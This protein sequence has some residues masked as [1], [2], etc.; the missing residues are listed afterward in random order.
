MRKNKPGGGIKSVT[1][2]DGSARPGQADPAENQH[3]QDSERKSYDWKCDNRYA[4]IRVE[5]V[6]RVQKYYRQGNNS[7]RM[8]NFEM[9]VSDAAIVLC[10]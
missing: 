4:K 6:W 3:E 5:S 8:A 1:N 7:G 10:H 9:R 2:N